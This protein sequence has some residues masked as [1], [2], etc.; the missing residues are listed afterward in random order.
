V[1][2]GLGHAQTL[3]T[4]LL[5]QAIQTLTSNDFLVHYNRD[6]H[7]DL[8]LHLRCLVAALRLLSFHGVQEGGLRFA[9]FEELYNRMPRWQEY[10]NNQVRRA[11]EMEDKVKNYD[12]EFLIVYATDLISSIPSDRSIAMNLTNRLISAAVTVGYAVK[13]SANAADIVQQT[14]CRR[15][16]IDPQDC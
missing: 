2:N 10:H 4:S 15:F 13:F 1:T 11:K 5:I 12:N 6:S 9:I 16:S 8:E 14:I 7:L 3:S